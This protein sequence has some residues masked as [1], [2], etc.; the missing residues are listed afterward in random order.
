VSRK[1]EQEKEEMPDDLITISEAADLRKR[2]VAAISQL[3]RRR[4]IH[5]YKQYGKTLVSRYEV[6]NYEPDKGGRPPEIK[7]GG[8][9]SKVNVKSSKKGGKK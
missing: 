6:L 3:V 4:R 2:T 1:R 9:D 8:S 5:G 7:A